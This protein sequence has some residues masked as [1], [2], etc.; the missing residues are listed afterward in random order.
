MVTEPLL[1]RLHA[2][3]RSLGINL[4]NAQLW[5]Y[6]RYLDLL[7]EWNRRFNLTAIVAPEEI[8]DKHFLDSLSCHLALD[9][10]TVLRLVDMGTGAGFPGMV[11]KIAFPHLEVLL[12][13][14][15]EKRLRFLQRVAEE[16]RLTD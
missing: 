6:A 10:T 16:L 7:L 4:T 8:I 14:A 1:E 12:L 3:A 15:V 13:D 5:S 2:G 9:F 11:L